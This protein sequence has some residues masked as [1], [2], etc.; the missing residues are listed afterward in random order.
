LKTDRFADNFGNDTCYLWGGN[1]RRLA[2]SGSLGIKEP[3]NVPVVGQQDAEPVRARNRE[4]IVAVVLAVVF[5]IWLLWVVFDPFAG[6]MS[7]GRGFGA[8]IRVENATASEV[9][10]EAFADHSEWNPATTAIA[11]GTSGTVDAG[12]GESSRIG[13]DLCTTVP[14]RALDD[15]G[16]ELERHDPPQCDGDV[17]VIDGR[18]G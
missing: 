15:R 6:F 9:T 2:S 11:P 12:F 14:L 7:E 3:D 4:A 8:A 13:R 17:W 18:D 10:I 1:F 5:T 16:L